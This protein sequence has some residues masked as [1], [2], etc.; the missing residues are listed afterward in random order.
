MKRYSII[1]DMKSCFVCGAEYNLHKHEAFFGIANRELSIKHG[2]VVALCGY[3]HNQSEKGVHGRDGHELDVYIKQT[4]QK[5]FE[6]TR[7]REEFRKIFGK[8]YILD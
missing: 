8:S 4:A 3:H 1:H 6:E 2:L 7:T 5:K